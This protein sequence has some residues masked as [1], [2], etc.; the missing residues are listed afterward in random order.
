MSRKIKIISV[1][2][3]TAGL[4]AC[5][6]VLYPSFGDIH[7]GVY[8]GDRE[9]IV[10]DRNVGA[11]NVGDYGNYYTWYDAVK[12]CPRGYH[13]MT[14]E[15]AKALFTDGKYTGMVERLHMPHAG[16]RRFNEETGSYQTRSEGEWG[17]YNLAEDRNFHESWFLQFD[18]SGNI[19]EFDYMTKNDRLS[20]RCIKGKAG[21]KVN[22]HMGEH[23]MLAPP[24]ERK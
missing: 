16:Y 9:I 14:M 12:V 17:N 6:K 19:F 8:I 21:K 15:E 20:V 11:D 3:L 18:S 2:A 4:I 23:M 22:F 7:T 24:A 10:A 13:V 1:I 5:A